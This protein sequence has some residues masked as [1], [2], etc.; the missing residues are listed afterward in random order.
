MADGHRVSGSEGLDPKGRRATVSRHVENI[1][2][3]ARYAPKWSLPANSLYLVVGRFNSCV[4]RMS[5]QREFKGVW[6]PRSVYLCEDLSWPEK[7]LLVE[8]HSLSQLSF[9][10]FATNKY[11]AGF[12]Q[13]SEKTLARYLDKLIST[14]LVKQQETEKGR[15]LSIPNGILSEGNGILSIKN[16]ILSNVF[17]EKSSIYGSVEPYNR[18]EQKVI[19]NIIDTNIDNKTNSEEEDLSKSGKTSFPEQ[20]N[21]PEFFGKGRLKRIVGFYSL[22]WW[23]HYGT[24]YRV[25]NWPAIGKHMKA[26][27]HLTEK[28]IA[29]LM[30]VHFDWYGATGDDD[31]AHKRL[32]SSMFPIM[33]LPNNENQ[34]ATFITNSVGVD[35]DDQDA[36]SEYV[37]RYVLVGGDGEDSLFARALQAGVLKVDH[38]N[39]RKDSVSGNDNGSSIRATEPEDVGA[40]ADDAR[41]E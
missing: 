18:A 3:L 7:V 29:A 24:R 2:S 15:N 31:F 5:K 25:T 9:G 19:D 37:R 39:I 13:V 34:Y 38:G 26:L 20:T 12:L 28:Q 40:H 17:T 41:G 36:V 27:E 23:E 1:S 22:L 32:E 6:I 16:G 8:I 30:I 21:L 10:C 33:W 4:G 14:G 35:F 11:L